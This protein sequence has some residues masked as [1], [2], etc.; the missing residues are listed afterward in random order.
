MSDKI[1]ELIS[2]LQR[3]HRTQIGFLDSLH[4]VE[5]MLRDQEALLHEKFSLAHERAAPFEA[6]TLVEQDDEN[7]PC[8]ACG[9]TDL[10]LFTDYRCPNCHKP[11][12]SPEEE[13]RIA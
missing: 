1:A 12:K 2:D 13:R 5:T 8:V 4:A 9:R 11:P 10:P 7:M 3:A 6:H